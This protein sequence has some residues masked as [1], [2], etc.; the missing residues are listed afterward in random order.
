VNLLVIAIGGA[1][2]SVSRYLLSS[3][4]LRVTGAKFPLG[5][6]VVNVIG[7]AIFGAIAGATSQRL[8]LSP[9]TK[10]FLFVG[11]LGGFTTFSSFAFES[12]S[13]LRDGQ[14]LA[15]SVNIAGQVVLGIAALWA[16][17]FLAR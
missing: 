16:G 15:A 12:V 2:G 1:V 13:L 7:C 14:L 3:L 8:T 5:T 10:L 4:L 17:Y 6:F 11:I 9:E